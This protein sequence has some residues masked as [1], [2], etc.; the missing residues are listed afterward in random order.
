MDLYPK[1]NTRDRQV[2]GINKT[3]F[4]NVSPD[5]EV[6]FL[7]LFTLYLSFFANC[8]HNLLRKNEI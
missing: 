4:T 1:N 8:T 2:N 5:N 6:L 3:K 7:E